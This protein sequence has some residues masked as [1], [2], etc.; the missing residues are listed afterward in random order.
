M[1]YYPLVLY[2]GVP[3]VASFAYEFLAKALNDF[4]EHPT[5]VRKKNALIIKM[6]AFQ[7]VNSY[8]ALLYVGF[9]LRD[10]NRLRQ[11]VMMMMMVKQF[12]AQI[13]EMYQPV[14]MR[15]LK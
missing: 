7:F 6:F 15:W 8:C 10:I 5:P 3:I 9:W 4:E 13:V 1:Q 11:L 12:V 2:S 14:L